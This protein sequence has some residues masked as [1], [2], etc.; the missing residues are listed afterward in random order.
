MM[1]PITVIILLRNNLSELNSW[2]WLRAKKE[3]VINNDNSF[4]NALDDVLNYQTIK[5]NPER[6]SKLKPYINKC[7]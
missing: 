4:Q 6:I 5:K 7:N 1:K 2:G 3:A